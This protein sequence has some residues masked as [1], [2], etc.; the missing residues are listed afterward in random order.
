M[1]QEADLTPDA[2]DQGAS[3]DASE[4]VTHD[5]AAQNDQTDAQIGLFAEF[6]YFLRGNIIWWLTPIVV[7]LAL[8]FA[9]AYFTNRS[10]PVP[11][12]YPLF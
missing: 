12:T 4:D 3:D 7:A 8:I 9:L 2:S 1:K 10:T 11:F 5:A 6:L